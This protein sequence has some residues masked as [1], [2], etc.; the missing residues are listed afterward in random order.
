MIL[1]RETISLTILVLILLAVAGP[2]KAASAASPAA[3]SVSGE[4]VDGLR[5][6]RI[7]SLPDQLHLKVYRG[8]YVQFLGSRGTA[9]LPLSIPG[10]GVALNLS[11]ASDEAPY[12]K[13]KDTGRF[14]ISVGKATGV[15]EVVA[16]ESSRY[17]E[18]TSRQAADLIRSA[19]P[20]VLD[21][22][23]RREYNQGHLAGSILIP[24]QELQQ[25]LTELNDYRNRDVVIYCATGNRS[26]VAAKILLDAGFERV[27]NIRY[28]IVDWWRNHLPIVR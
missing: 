25:R 16:Y 5:V 18:L 26:T 3:G 21:V 19:D 24:V 13:M 12:F 8:D 27:Y 11:T 17:R 9:G 7:F 23:T 1:R 20:V 6:I 15:L 14:G 4:L 22:R 10:L 2:G 28:G